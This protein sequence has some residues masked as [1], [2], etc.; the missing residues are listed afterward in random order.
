MKHL[1]K[2]IV[3][4]AVVSGGLW[5]L[6][7]VLARRFEHGAGYADADEFRIAAVWG[8]REFT[9]TTTNLVSG[10]AVAVLAGIALDLRDAKLGPN[11]ASLAL[12]ATVG[13]ISVTVPDDWRVVVDRNVR[14]GGVEVRTTDPDLLPDDAPTL[15][16][17]ATAHTGGIVITTADER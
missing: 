2:V 13:G 11:G 10:W 17:T 1:V 15:R 12:R 9:S 3:A 8:G 16:V 14:A 6:G 5:G 4:T 7:L